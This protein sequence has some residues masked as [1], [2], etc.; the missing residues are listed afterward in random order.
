MKKISIILLCIALSGCFQPKYND[1]EQTISFK[2]PK[3]TTFT[4]DGFEKNASEIKVRRSFSSLKGTL[5]KEGFGS[6]KIEIKSHF[7]DDKWA[8]D[9]VPVVNY[10]S[11][12]SAINLIPLV[13]TVKYTALGVATGAA[14][15]VGEYGWEGAFLSP[16]GAVALGGLGLIS[17]VAADTFNLLIL[18]LPCA[19]IGNPWYEYDKEI[20]LSAEVLTPTP[21]FEKKCHSQKDHF[22]GNYECFP[23]QKNKAIY[24]TQAECEH[25]PNRE[26]IDGKCVLKCPNGFRELDKGFC[27]SCQDKN[28]YYTTEET[29]ARCPDRK[30]VDGECRLE[31]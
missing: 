19:I 24:T 12:Q 26:F 5:S 31:K 16:F 28:T 4:M 3:G 30:W 25:C 6:K 22:V 17:G 2:Y 9:F 10:L 27:V 20:D 7:T 23:C 8:K 13:P 21:E 11:D 18:S 1:Y 29:C 15:P 14:A